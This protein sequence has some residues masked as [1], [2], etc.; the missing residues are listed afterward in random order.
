MKFTVFLVVFSYSILLLLQAKGCTA[1]PD[2]WSKVIQE[3]CTTFQQLPPQIVYGHHYTQQAVM[4]PMILL[5]PPV[6]LWSP[7]EQFP[8][9]FTR[10]VLVCPDCEKEG[11]TS[12]LT[13]VRWK[14]G[15]K[16]QRTEPR[17]IHGRDG[18]VFLVARVYRCVNSHEILATDPR[19][20]QKQLPL[21]STLLPFS[22]WH[23][24][25]YTRDVQS[26]IVLLITAGLSI[27]AVRDTI[28]QQQYN[29][30]LRSQRVY[31]ELAQLYTTNGQITFNDV[32]P[33]PSFEQYSSQLPKSITPSRHAITGLFLA[34]FDNTKETYYNDMRATTIAD[35]DSWLSC[36]HTFACAGEFDLLLLVSI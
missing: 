15:A 7:T 28:Q 30:F 27:S 13:A 2:S 25:G 6:I 16:G 19:V 11:K 26:Q 3:L 22:L 1:F 4:D 34:D 35:S 29:T 8:H 5:M 33:F 24:T 18:I 31:T 14:D 36:N 32:K 9:L 20:Y 17:K 12:H 10:N 23:I 21:S